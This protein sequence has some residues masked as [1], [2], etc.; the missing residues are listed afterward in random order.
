MGVEAASVAAGLTLRTR[1]DTLAV[2]AREP[3]EAP[4]VAR[5][6]VVLVGEDVGFTA[7]GLVPVTV[8]EVLE[9]GDRAQAFPAGGGA[10]LADRAHRGAVAAVLRV[11]GQVD[12]APVAKLVAVAVREA[13]LAAPVAERLT[14]Y[15]G[16]V[17]ARAGRVASA[18]VARVVNDVHAR[19]P[20]ADDRRL[21][22]LH[23]AHARR[24]DFTRLTALGAPAAVVRVG[25]GVGALAEAE[26]LPDEAGT[27]AVRTGLAAAA[28]LAAPTAVRRVRGRVDA[29]AGA[30]GH[31]TRRDQVGRSRRGAVDHREEIRHGRNDEIRRRRGAG[32]DHRDTAVAGGRTVERG[33]GAGVQRVG[34]RV[35]ETRAGQAVAAVEAGQARAALDAEDAAAVDGRLVAVLLPILGAEVRRSARVVLAEAALAV[36]R[37]VAVDADL[38]LVDVAAGEGGAEQERDAESGDELL[39]G[40]LLS[41]RWSGL[42]RPA[43]LPDEDVA[44]GP[45]RA[46]WNTDCFSY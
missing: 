40:L 30:E 28:G 21:P 35:V 2:L 44:T 23:L 15:R 26:E 9:T 45:S 37:D 5:P 10:V 12:L 43:L 16:H 11:V 8:T 38:A 25:Q 3:V 32:I 29:L 33:G 39:H 34:A 17:G 18:A 41:G 19:V 20:V 31:A 1:H 6:T 14:G 7:G 42:P 22:A 36:V 46:T 24:A 13:L 27:R 4:V